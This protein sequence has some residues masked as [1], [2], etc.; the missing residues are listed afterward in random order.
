[1]WRAQE[2]AVLR[3]SLLGEAPSDLWGSAAL[4]CYVVGAGLCHG[5]KGPAGFQVHAH[6]FTSVFLKAALC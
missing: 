5:P 4:L 3:R 2:A 6:A 1:M